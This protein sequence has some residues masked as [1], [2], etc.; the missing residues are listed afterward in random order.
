MKK[1]SLA[2]GAATILA[3]GALFVSLGEDA[4]PIEP[5]LKEIGNYAQI[6]EKGIVKTIIVADQEFINS[7]AVGDPTKWIRTD[8]SVP[9]K[10]AAVGGKYDITSQ[11]FIT[12]EDVRKYGDTVEKTDVVKVA[13]VSEI[14]TSTKSK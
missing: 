14:S 10:A 11:E 1:K 2:I 12:K 13:P 8:Y 7:G 3:T 6:D 4:K 9:E 5:G